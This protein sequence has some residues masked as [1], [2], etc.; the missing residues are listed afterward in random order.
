MEAIPSLAPVDI[1]RITTGGTSREEKDSEI[2]KEKVLDVLLIPV[3]IVKKESIKID[4]T[5]KTVVNQVEEVDKVACFSLRQAP[6]EEKSDFNKMS[7]NQTSLLRIDIKS[8]SVDASQDEN[9]SRREWRTLHQRTKGIVNTLIRISE[10]LEKIEMN[11]TTVEVTS[12]LSCAS[13]LTKIIPGMLENL[14][15]HFVR[16]KVYFCESPPKPMYLTKL[17]RKEEKEMKNDTTSIQVPLPVVVKTEPI[18]IV[19]VRKSLRRSE[20]I[21][22]KEAPENVMAYLFVPERENYC[23]SL[24]AQTS[25][26]KFTRKTTLTEPWH[27]IPRVQE[28]NNKGRKDAANQT[29]KQYKLTSAGASSMPVGLTSRPDPNRTQQG[30][31]A[32]TVPPQV[33]HTHAGPQ[34]AGQQPPLFPNPPPPFPPYMPHPQQQ[35]G[36]QAAA[37]YQMGMP[38]MANYHGIPKLFV[39][40]FDG[41]P[42]EYQRFKVSF[43]A[44]YDDNRHLPQKHLALLLESRLKGRPLTIISEYMRTC[45]DDS[46]YTRMWQ[47]LDERYGGKE[48]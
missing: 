42:E 19:A 25:E 4:D 44:A 14:T 20:I 40:I 5:V 10:H 30:A 12:Y 28:E 46:S 11:K 9:S 32:Q 38:P 36:V 8:P 1:V 31:N 17:S 47:L 37:R 43:I 24:S 39:K 26:F 33:S 41:K 27:E 15:K 7:S 16:E 2:E 34:F 23:E 29:A 6:S 22:K 21:P 48:R 18:E 3:D 35:Q 45:I 13:S